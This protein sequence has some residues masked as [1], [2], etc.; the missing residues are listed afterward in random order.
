[1]G[2]VAPF[3]ADVHEVFVRLVGG[4]GKQTDGNSCRDWLVYIRGFSGVLARGLA[5]HKTIACLKSDT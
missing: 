1:M 5:G 3:G 2:A 4:G